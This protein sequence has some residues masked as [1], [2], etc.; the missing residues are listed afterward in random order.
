MQTVEEQLAEA[1]AL[2]ALAPEHRDVIAGCTRNRVFSDGEWIM[3]E[4]DPSDAFYVIRSGSVALETRVPAR[5][6]VTVETLHDGDLLGWSWLVPPYRTAFDARSVG[7]THVRAI[8]G[9][10]L[11]GKCEADHALGYDLL[12]LVA[13]VFVERL[14]DTRLRLLDLYGTVGQ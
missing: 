1:P 7:P 8:D 6:S 12:K 9:A 14:R 13:S 3:H 5:G 2:R 10:C 4:G 11:R